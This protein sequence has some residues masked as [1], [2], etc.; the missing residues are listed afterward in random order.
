MAAM[1]R[2]LG[3]P[4]RIAPRPGRASTGFPSTGPFVAFV[5]AML[6]IGTTPV[7]TGGGVHQFSLVHPLF[8]HVHL[9]AGR[10]L[11]HEQLK[12]EGTVQNASTASHAQ[13]PR[14]GPALGAGSAAGETDAGLA[15]SPTVPVPP[16]AVLLGARAGLLEAEGIAPR[17]RVVAPPDPPPTRRAG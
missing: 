10:L 6:L 4:A 5:L 1:H 11:T 16:S 8:S 12:L 14:S 15:L 2:Q 3:F 9:Y 17:G 7:G 13:S